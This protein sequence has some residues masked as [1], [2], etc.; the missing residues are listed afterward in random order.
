M[1]HPKL[2]KSKSRFINVNMNPIINHLISST[3]SDQFWRSYIESIV[4]GELKASIHL[5]VFIEPFLSYVFDGKKTIESR[6]SINRISPFE[7]VRK[8]D[9][10]LLKKS[11]GP[12]LG[13]CRIKDAWFYRL[14]R[15]LWK[16]IRRDYSDAI[17]ATD[18]S[19]WRSKEK[20]AFATLMEIDRVYRVE[21]ITF[22]KKDRRG[23]MTLADRNNQFE[24]FNQTK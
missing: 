20:A 13:I 8:D 17:C 18:S 21:P 9:I 10:I 22:S 2:K 5:A 15:K 6:F 24:I 1:K 12:V 14:D 23:W 16:E 7:K 19:F 3:N 11:G 4:N